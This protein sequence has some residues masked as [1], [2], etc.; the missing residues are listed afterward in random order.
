MRVEIEINRDQYLELEKLGFGAFS[1]VRGF[2]NS[3][4]FHSVVE[5]MRLP[6]G[7]PFPLPILLDLKPH[8]AQAAKKA[9]TLDLIFEGEHVGEVDCEELFS[10]DKHNTAE[11]VFGT[12]DIQH[13]GVA[14]LYDMGEVFIGG[15]VRLKKRAAFEFSSYELTPSETK[16]LFA[17]KGWKT[18]VG[19]QTR[20]VPHRAHE[21]LQRIALEYVDGLF[22]QPLVGRKKAGDYT[23]EAILTGYKALIDGFYPKNRVVLGILSTAMRYAGPREAVFH[24]II[25]RNYGCTHFVIGR[26]HAGVG[27]YYQKY[28]GHALARKFEGELGIKTLLLHGP[29]FCACCGGIVTEHTCPHLKTAE[30]CTRQINGTDIREMLLNRTPIDDEIIRQEVVDSIANMNIFIE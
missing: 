20:N 15:N 25:R 24:A 19:F 28:E 1:P 22:I 9:S 27:G 29:Y 4:Q 18:I 2:M 30:N 12:T 21:Y 10:I 7:E 6:N 11:K 5:S 14:H 16:Q 17:E 13:P 8:Q 26:D 3:R 23:P